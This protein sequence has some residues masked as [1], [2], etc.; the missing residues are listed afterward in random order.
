MG[1]GMLTDSCLPVEGHVGRE[2]SPVSVA[3]MG[4]D[5]DV[6]PACKVLFTRI[7]E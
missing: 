3:E 5:N 4:F 6:R 2:M 7:G 1:T